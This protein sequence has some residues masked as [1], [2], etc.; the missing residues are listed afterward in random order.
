MVLLTASVFSD[1]SISSQI[2][3]FSRHNRPFARVRTACATLADDV[4]DDMADDV[5]A[6]VAGNVF[7][8]VAY[9][10]IDDVASDVIDDVAA[11]AAGDVADDV[12]LSNHHILQLEIDIDEALNSTHNRLSIVTDYI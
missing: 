6:D 8:C 10:V 2:Y 5:D 11:D 4:S 7:D 3:P 9:D 12:I 1:E